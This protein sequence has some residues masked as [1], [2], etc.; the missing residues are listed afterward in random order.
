MNTQPGNT[1]PPQV[2]YLPSTCYL[3]AYRLLPYSVFK[4]LE[5]LIKMF[6]DTPP[7]VGPFFY[8]MACQAMKHQPINEDARRLRAHHGELD[9]ERDY[10]V[11]EY[12]APS[13]PDPNGRMSVPPYFC[14]IL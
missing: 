1:P 6:T 7:W 13:E 12:P 9:G 10:F 2:Y 4:D 14:G 5:K 3:I 11:L 8:L